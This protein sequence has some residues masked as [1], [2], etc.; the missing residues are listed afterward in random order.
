VRRHDGTTNVSR[1]VHGSLFDIA[2]RRPLRATNAERRDDAE[3]RN[4]G[5]TPADAIRWPST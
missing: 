2:N 3:Q 1:V 4:Q 5:L